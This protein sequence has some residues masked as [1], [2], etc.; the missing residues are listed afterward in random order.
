MTDLSRRSTVGLGL[1][2]AAALASSRARAQTPAEVKIAML[3]PLSGPW[4]RQ[5]I[6][7]QMGARLAI[8]DV[9]AAGGIKSMGGAKLKL[10]EYDT[11]DSAEKAKDAAQRMI[12]QEPDLVG[13]FGC[14]L[15]TFT[16]AATEVTER[17]GLPWL[18]LSYSDAI[19]GRGF[20]HVFQSSPTA[21]AQA[22]ETLP[23]VMELAQ[24][25]TGKKPTKVAFVGDNT[26]AS[27][28]FMKPVRDHVVKDLGLTTV[29]DEVYTPPLADA[30]TM[31][32]H[33][34]SG[35]PDFLLFG[36]T[37]V[38]DD[39]LLVDKFAE[40]NLKSDRLPKIGNG[41]HWAVPELLKNAGAENLEGILVGLANWPGKRQADLEQR[42]MKRTGEPWFGHDSIFAYI[43]VMIL[44]EALE[45]CGVAD[46]AKVSD[47]IHALD[48]TDGPA[49][50]FPDGRLKYDEKGRRVGAKLC[51]VQ[52]R[53]GKPV[54]VFP[55]AIATQDV[56]WP[57]A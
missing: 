38:P 53:G 11:Q 30:T 57:K 49:L 36:S 7:E 2:T 12:A 54:P 24:K 5:G 25:A 16:L 39:K 23:M 40:F 55:A 48:M 45:K 18:T 44:K 41:G 31:V 34:R 43:H 26:A 21:D 20:K 37:N 13:G 29:A 27:V 4:A 51:V 46:R 9:N 47:A 15:S 19:T 14:W 8:D 10:V 42:F 56:L 35:R 52:W 17:A 3:V 22:E 32:Q 1:A 33:V 50:F 6:L 28:S